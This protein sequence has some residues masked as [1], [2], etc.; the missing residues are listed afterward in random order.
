MQTRSFI[1]VLTLG[2]LS[3]VFTTASFAAEKKGKGKKAATT[4][5]TGVVEA[6]DS[7]SIKIRGL[8]ES[9]TFVVNDNTMVAT[10]DKKEAAIGDVKCGTTVTVFFFVGPR[11]R[12]IAKT[13]APTAVANPTSMVSGQQAQGTINLPCRYIH[14]TWKVDG[15][16]GAK[17]DERKRKQLQQVEVTFSRMGSGATPNKIKMLVH[18]K[19][20][21]DKSK[22]EVA[23]M[24]YK[25]KASFIE[26][27][28]SIA[29]RRISHRMKPTDKEEIIFKSGDVKLRLFYTTSDKQV[30]PELFLGGRC[31]VL[32][33]DP[34]IA[35]L[36]R[37]IN[38]L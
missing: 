35:A 1:A 36:V 2:A 19:S 16:S 26:S 33:S 8:T 20:G 30:L 18:S 15:Y 9:K 11:G 21:T 25:D 29:Q 14:T 34:D 32:H 28:K 22:D 38:V 4:S 12:S 5:F 37:E 24:P 31:I 3:L 6:C 13:I 7:G 17:Y 23:T 27:L 10:A